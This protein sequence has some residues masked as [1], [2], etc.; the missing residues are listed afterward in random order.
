MNDIKNFSN[1]TKTRYFSKKLKKYHGN[2]ASIEQLIR[3]NDVFVYGSHLYN[4]FNAIHLSK[5]ELK[6]QVEKN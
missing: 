1:A 3:N 5:S 2:F 4:H 6:V